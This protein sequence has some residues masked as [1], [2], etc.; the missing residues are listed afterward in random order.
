MSYFNLALAYPAVALQVLSVVALLLLVLS[1]ENRFLGWIKKHF[2]ILG[3]VI[4]LV[5]TLSSLFYSEVVGFI[6]CQLCWIQRIFM[7]PLVF[8]FGVAL[9]KRDRGVI[10]YSL[11]LVLIGTLFSIYHNFIYYF[12]ESTA[13]CDASGVSCVKRL[14]AVFDGY[15]S[16]PML[17]L[18]SFV[19]ILSILLVAY[20]YKKGNNQ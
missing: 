8:I 16:I 7:Y 3:F 18:T 20:F 1:R 12:G 19:S 9:L 4:S 13:P 17:A 5:A 15:V 11:P 2:L 14:V 6:P 10:K